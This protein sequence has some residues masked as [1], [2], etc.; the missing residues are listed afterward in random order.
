LDE[1]TF[2]A[3]DSADSEHIKVME[4]RLH[5]QRLIEDKT[6][7]IQTIVRKRQQEDKQIDHDTR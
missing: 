7:E 6:H 1:S 3:I 4:A 2:S 5:K